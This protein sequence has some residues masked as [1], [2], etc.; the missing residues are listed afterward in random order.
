[1]GTPRRY[2]GAFGDSSKLSARHKKPPSEVVFLC[3]VVPNLFQDWLGARWIWKDL[4]GW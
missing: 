3:L 1:V 2:H 4:T